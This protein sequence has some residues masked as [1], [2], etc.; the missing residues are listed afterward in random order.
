MGRG[1]S[2]DRHRGD[3]VLDRGEWVATCRRCGFRVSD[4]DRRQVASQFR[5]HIRE[6]ALSDAELTD[7]LLADSV[8]SESVLSDSVLSESVLSESVLTESVRKADDASFLR[9]RR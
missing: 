2:E 7:P 8:L 3:Y 9:L 5:T 6:S 4:S 1:S